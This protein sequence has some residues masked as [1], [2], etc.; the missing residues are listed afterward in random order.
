MSK[1][2]QAPLMSFERTLQSAS[3]SRHLAAVRQELLRRGVAADP[4]D[5]SRYLGE[6]A[7]R[8]AVRGDVEP[9][10][11]GGGADL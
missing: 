4:D 11:F 9:D 7:A 3:D 10:D 6:R 1:K 2:K 5:I 8:E